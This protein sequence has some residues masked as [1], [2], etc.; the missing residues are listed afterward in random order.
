[1]TNFIR[2]Y[3]VQPDFGRAMVKAGWLGS[4]FTAHAEMLAH[5]IKNASLG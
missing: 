2:L 1:M 3:S 4:R 5:Q